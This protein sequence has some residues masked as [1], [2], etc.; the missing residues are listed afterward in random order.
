MR[1]GWKAVREDEI[2]AEDLAEGMAKFEKLVL[3]SPFYIGQALAERRTKAEAALARAKTGGVFSLLEGL[4]AGGVGPL[5]ELVRDPELFEPLFQRGVGEHFRSGLEKRVGPDDKIED[6]ETL[7]W[8]AGVFRISG[9]LQTKGKSPR[10]VT[11][12][13]AG[14]NS[15]MLV[16]SNPIYGTPR[17]FT[18]RDCTIHTSGSYLLDFRHQAAAIRFERT[19]FLG[20]DSV[21][22]GTHSLALSVIDCRIEGGY[23]GGTQ[24]GRLWDVRTDALVARFQSCSLSLIHLDVGYL[25]SGATVLFEGCSLDE[26]LDD[27]EANAAAHPGV[28]FENCTITRHEGDWQTIPKLDL[29]TLFPDWKNRME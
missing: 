3:K 11:I 24:N 14:M 8:P 26:I 10:D 18:I 17:N 15:T 6:G 25:R 29:N 22:L 23:G 9:H 19:R 20:F 27:P 7:T 13:G 21:L 5:P 12:A 2:P 28:M 16:L 1:K 4:E